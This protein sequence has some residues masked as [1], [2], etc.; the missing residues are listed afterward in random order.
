[1]E[2]ARVMDEGLRDFGR[3]FIGLLGMGLHLH[4]FIIAAHLPFN[5]SDYEWNQF[6]SK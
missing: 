4:D 3:Q 6:S 5:D 1:M 2:R